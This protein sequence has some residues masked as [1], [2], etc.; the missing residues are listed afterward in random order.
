[1]ENVLRKYH[2][3]IINENKVLLVEARLVGNLLEI[4]N[5]RSSISSFSQ[6]ERCLL[7]RKDITGFFQKTICLTEKGFFKLICLSR[8]PTAVKIAT[9]LGLYVKHKYVVPEISFVNNIK[10]AFNSETIICQYRVD[11]FLI[12]LYFPEYNLVIEFDEVIHK[13]NINKD[14]IRQDYITDKIKS[15]F[16]RIGEKDN[17]FDSINIIRTFIN[18]TMTSRNTLNL[19]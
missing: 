13:F 5:I 15:E 8:K 2:I 1:M 14:K 9:E 7:Y 12:D 19:T 6:D 11:K 17:I 3:D 4:I 18:K 16:I 10:R